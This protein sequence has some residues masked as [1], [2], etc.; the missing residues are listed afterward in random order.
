MSSPVKVLLQSKSVASKLLDLLRFTSALM[1]V[2]FHF[3]TPPW[4]HGPLLVWKEFVYTG[5]Q[6]VMV[7]FVLS[8]YFIGSNVILTIWSGK[9]SWKVYLVNRLTRLWTV[10]LPAL[11]LTYIWFLVQ[12]HWF[13]SHFI[14]EG[15]H[16]NTAVNFKTLVANIFFMQDLHAQMFGLNNPLWSLSFEFWYY[17]LFPL[18]LLTFRSRKTS[19]KF[20]SG[21]LFCVVA[22]IVGPKVLEYFLV[23]LLGALVSLV[24]PINI[25]SGI[26]Q[27]IPLGATIILLGSMKVPTVFRVYPVYES[28]AP[29]QFAFD[30][31]VGLSCALLVYVILSSYS[32]VQAK[33]LKIASSL[34]GFSY[35]LYLVH[36][37]VISFITAAAHDTMKWQINTHVYL[38]FVPFGTLAILAYAW[39]ISILTERHTGRIRHMIL[40]ATRNRKTIDRVVER[41]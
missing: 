10:L 24:K 28:T 12:A 7:F 13:G 32:S 9:W 14:I 19:N 27:L 21:I 16:M 34:A 3:G 4:N 36:Y 35:T 29:H 15:I 5:Y 18:M 6:F 23:W 30:F 20:I 31:L 33:K 37:P 11:F 25:T 26:K 22:V 1:V 38:E 40:D 2:L 8:G 41:A 39:L 17:I